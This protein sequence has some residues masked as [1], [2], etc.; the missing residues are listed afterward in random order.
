MSAL[1]K[2][3]AHGNRASFHHASESGNESSLAYNQELLAMSLYR[4]NP[5]LRVAMRVIANNFLWGGDF[6]RKA[7]AIDE[8]VAA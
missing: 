1:E 7:N 6:C 8:E 3:K 5:E 4:S 2:F